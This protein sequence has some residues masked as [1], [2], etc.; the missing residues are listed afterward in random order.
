MAVMHEPIEDGIGERGFADA[1]VPLIDGEL[2]GESTVDGS[3]ANPSSWMTNLRGS[4]N[5][6]A[7][8]AV[9]HWI[10]RDAC[11]SPVMGT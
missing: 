2:T 3:W 10:E 7:E 1:G 6:Y 11:Y 8:N 4:V 9:D 5:G